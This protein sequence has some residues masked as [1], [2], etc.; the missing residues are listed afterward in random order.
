LGHSILLHEIFVGQVNA[1]RTTVDVQTEL[2]NDH[3]LREM[4]DGVTPYYIRTYPAPKKWCAEAGARGVWTGN[5][6]FDELG[7]GNS[8]KGRS[9]KRAKQSQI[10]FISYWIRAN[11]VLLL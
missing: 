7:T 10:Q 11:G 3:V 9:G 8:R 4:P 1:P 2:Q 5:Q 6:N